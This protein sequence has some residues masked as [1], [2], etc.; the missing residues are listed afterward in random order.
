VLYVT[1][2][3]SPVIFSVSKLHICVALGVVQRV[4]DLNASPW[5][6]YLAFNFKGFL[7]RVV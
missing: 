3:F 2:S 5:F 6:H 4:T 1:D 7:F